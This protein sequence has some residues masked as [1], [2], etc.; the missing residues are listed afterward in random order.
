VDTE[1]E[2]RADLVV[3]G[4]GITGLAA[5]WTAGKFGAETVLL[6]S[7]ERFGGSV[8]THRNHGYVVE[9][10]PHSL[11]VNDSE[12]EAFLKD[13]GL[14]D[15]AVETSD[16][17]GKR[18]IVR[19][20]RPV[21]LPSSPFGFVTSPFLSVAGKCRL[22]MEPFLH[23][24][25]PEGEEAIGPWVE[26][27]FGREVREG[28]ADP[29]ISGIYAGDPD[30]ISLQAAFPLLANIAEM[31]PS[32][33]RAFFQKRKENKEKGIERYP[34]KML[35]FPD[36]LG[37][38]VGHLVRKGDFTAR[39]GVRLRSID[40]DQSEWRIRYRIGSETEVKTLRTP[41]LLVAV[42]PSAL[43]DL[44]FDQKIRENLATMANVVAPPVT[45][46]SIAF[47]R[48]EVGHPLDGFGMLCPS[49]ENRE[50]LGILFDS[51]LFPQRAPEGEVLLSA[52]LGGA[53]TPENAR[54][55]TESFLRIV[56]KECKEL[57][58]AHG[59]PTYWKSTYWPRAIPQYNLG[60]T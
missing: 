35:S 5:A 11:L 38:M 17:A 53:R 60:L 7:S 25:R 43:A 48:K 52:F 27:H 46:F 57:L 42:P 10:G 41:K 20:G 44:P 58:D 30:K 55:D 54:H 16:A 45:T 29:F 23:G 4:G 19:N 21:A 3:L 59:E 14:W 47:K 36:G 18:F 8:I 15:R 49:R 24:T 39:P 33:I 12:L 56:K 28:L 2:N 13:C 6:E 1:G 51:S 32:L 9:G 37:E 50:V 40:R 34:R 26:R 22:M 31:H